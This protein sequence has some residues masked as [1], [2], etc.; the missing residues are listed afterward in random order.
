MIES[1]LRD[2]SHM[3]LI[4]PRNKDTSLPEFQKVMIDMTSD[5]NGSSILKEIGMPNGFEILTREDCEF[6]I[7][8]MD[9][10]LD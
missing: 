3:L 1:H 10:L 9:T 8:L 4:H 6:L 5:P 2:I 7:D